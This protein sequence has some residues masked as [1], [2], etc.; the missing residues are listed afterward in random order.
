MRTRSLPVLGLLVGLTNPVAAQWPPSAA[1][2]LAIADFAGEQVLNK[3]ATTSD[4]G[5]WLGWFDQRGGSYAVYVQRLDAAGVEQ[6]AHGGILVSNNPQSSS[7]V[8][9]DLICDSQDF[10]V[11]AFTDTRAG[12]DLDVYAYRIAPNG[13]LVWGANGVPLSNN[14]DYEPSPRVCEA[15]DGDFVFAWANTGVATLQ[16]QRLDPAGVP[17]FAGDGIAIP[18]DAGAT[19]AFVRIAAADNG[20][21]ILSWVRALAFA[22]TKH[23]HMQKVTALGAQAWNGGTRIAVFDQASVPI[24]HEPRLLPDGSGGAI[25]AW[26]FAAGSLF[27]VRVQ[28]VLANG[29]EAFAHNGVDVST[30]GNS[31]FDP[32]IVWQPPLQAAFVVWNE[33]NLGQSMWGIFAQRI[34]A[35]GTLAWGNG[36]VQLRAIDT[37]E[38]LTPVAAPYGAVGITAAVLETSLGAQQRQVTVF[39]LDTAGTALFPPTAASTVASDKLRLALA[40]TPSGTSVVAWT[41][42]RT[43]G[44]DVFVHALDAGGSR[45]IQLATAAPY[46]CGVNPAG[47]LV[48]VGRPA[49]GMESG[50][51]LSDPLGVWPAGLIGAVFLCV[52]A[53]PGFPCGVVAGGFGMAGGG[54]PGEIL[55]DI[56]APNLPLVDTYGGPGTMVSVAFTLP[57][58][59]VLLGMPLYAQGAVVDLP[60]FQ[61]GLSN[62]L[63][64]TLGS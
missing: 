22:G 16:V 44:G 55:V 31:K 21:V 42:K 11:L 46:G 49:I 32:A 15:S 20:S 41:D 3:V 5:A 64:L 14:G 27:S 25:C 26:H 24:A 23:V 17:R 40:A 58:D 52:Q 18:G 45:T 57:L 47:S 33:R 2:N 54:A 36:G 62:G 43:D 12:G 10:C 50:F 19:P 60:A 37:I 35:G 39:G 8:D 51:Q 4:G 30:S 7:L 9:W 34:D 6:F 48:P 13:S 59:Q 61:F 38:K 29:T 1:T 63:A 53:A 28:H 56:G